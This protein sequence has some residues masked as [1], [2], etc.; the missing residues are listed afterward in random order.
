MM[1]EALQK[2]TTI[3][4]S[5][6]FLTSD[7]ESSP[8]HA[9]LIA[10]D[11]FR[12]VIFRA[13]FT[14]SQ[15]GTK[16]GIELMKAALMAWVIG[17][18]RTALGICFNF[19]IDPRSGDFIRSL[20]RNVIGTLDD[21]KD[22]FILTPKVRSLSR[23]N[24]IS[25][26]NQAWIGRSGGRDSFTCADILSRLGFRL[27]PYKIAYDAP[28]P[29]D[30]SDYATLEYDIAPE[31]GSYEPFD[32]PLTYLAPFWS[33]H[34]RGPE[35]LAVGHS[36]DVFG[37]TGT[38][39]SAPY[40]SPI[41]MAIH[42]EYLK[43]MLGSNSTRLVFPIATLSTHGV[44]EYIR[45]RFGRSALESHVSCWNSTAFDC[46]YCRKCQRIKLATSAMHE[47]GRRHLADVPQVLESHSD[48][49][50]HPHYDGLVQ[51]YGSDCL[52]EAQLLSPNVAVDDRF[53]RFLYDKFTPFYIDGSKVSQHSNETASEMLPERIKRLL[54]IDYATLPDHPVTTSPV[55]LPYEQYFDRKHPI[56]SC[57]GRIPTYHP[58]NGWGTRYLGE[59]PQL[60]VPDTAV[61]R[62]FF[63][64][65][66]HE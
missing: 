33:I 44:F 38:Q 14:A 41:A 56:L 18:F 55:L 28:V 34:D 19:D 64:L 24:V 58:Q 10:R 13:K 53:A 32:I 61:F 4:P 45:R 57:H 66:R 27:H 59:G 6:S 47:E 2:I 48:L 36:F 16:L 26:P 17:R 62:N 3:G 15:P 30:D 43:Q 51:K 29:Q 11:A 7:F 31:S 60:T 49:F 35:A 25:I 65:N 42:Q 50:G 46:G 22:T 20:R 21:A 40:E 12:R 37:F 9:T 23:G 1:H 39:R 5:A 63:Y 52:A 54:E 8:Y